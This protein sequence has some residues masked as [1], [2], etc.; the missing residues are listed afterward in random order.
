MLIW[1]HRCKLLYNA[2][3]SDHDP[4]QSE[5]EWL[6]RWKTWWSMLDSVTREQVDSN[7][8]RCPDAQFAEKMKERIEQAQTDHDSIGGNIVCVLRNVPAGLGEPC[9]DKLEAKLAHAMMSIPATKG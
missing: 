4:S 2:L 9:F 1:N 7:I 5:E 3:F 8:V 6:K